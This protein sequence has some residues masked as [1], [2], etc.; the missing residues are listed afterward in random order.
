M[1]AGAGPVRVRPLA[2]PGEPAALTPT[3]VIRLFRATCATAGE[4]AP[5]LLVLDDYLVHFT[6]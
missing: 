3:D 6:G 4:K 5:S 1:I 2:R